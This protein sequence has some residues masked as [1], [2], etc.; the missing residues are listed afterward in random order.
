MIRN[1]CLYLF[2][3]VLVGLA[4]CTKDETPVGPLNNG[5]GIRNQIVV[6]YVPGNHDLSIT[7]ENVEKVLKSLSNTAIGS[8]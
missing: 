2:G 7:A 8:S 3:I 5:S 6:T 1:T 4:S